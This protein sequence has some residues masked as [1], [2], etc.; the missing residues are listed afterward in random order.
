MLPI[1]EISDVM[2]AF[3]ADPPV[4]AQDEIPERYRVGIDLPVVTARA[5]A[6]GQPPT[7]VEMRPRD[8]VDAGKAIRA[9][10]A[11]LGS[12]GLKHE[13]KVAAVA[14]MLDEWFSLNRSSSN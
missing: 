1:P 10:K 9:I 11:A 13:H 8:G 14:Y 2:L 7:D 4:P 12:F 5:L 6:V 3:P